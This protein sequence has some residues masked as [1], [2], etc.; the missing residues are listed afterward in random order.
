MRHAP[1]DAERKLWQCLRTGQIEGL[2]F[3]RQHPIP[4]YIAD[5]CCVERK[6]IV[7]LDGG[8]HN[9]E[10][11]GFRT[12]QL[13]AQGWVVLRFWDNDVLLNIESV[14]EAI[15]HA[16]AQRTL[17]PTPLPEGEGLKQSTVENVSEANCNAIAQRTLTPTPLPEGEGLKQSTV[18]NV[19]EANCNAVA[20]RTLTP[21]PLPGEEGLNGAT[22]T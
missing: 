15:C 2:K 5:F 22:R 6:L 1:T 9:S 4:P 3:R 7:E 14:V 18:E 21:T 12:R 8:Q 20:Q 17:T 19:S 10:V 16:I 13:E 11:D